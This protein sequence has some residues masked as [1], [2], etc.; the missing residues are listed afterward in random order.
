MDTPGFGHLPPFVTDA[1]GAE[2]GLLA[3]QR[4]RGGVPKIF[5]TNTAAE[6]WRGDCA[7]LHIDPLSKRDLDLPADSRAYLFAG[8]QHGSGIV[9]LYRH[10]PLDGTRG[11]HS[12]NA[13]D[14][15]PLLRAALSNLDAWVTAG[16]E[17]PSSAVPRLADGTAVLNT[18]A[19]DAYRNIPGATVPEPAWL[20]AL[21]PTDLG[22]EAAQ[23]IG[24]FPAIE[25]KPYPVYVSATDSDGNEAAGLRL[26][27]VSVPV[28][29]H[30][31]WNPRGAGIGGAGQ[32][33]ALQGST[34][35]FART[36]A[37]REASADPRPAINERYQGRTD[38]LTRVR[39]A[40]EKLVAQRALL[41]EDL[42]M[43]LR[44]TAE[45]YDALRGDGG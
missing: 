2:E 21:R 40:A 35:P 5:F 28:A 16:T 30:T 45:R 27:D 7:L 12:F 11:A 41:A 20:P 38:Y 32:L 9:P 18:T 14:Y 33:V 8:T 3:R 34:I 37:A 36:A 24:R 17:P 43:A 26:P 10:N 29:T 25:G 23:G 31:G 39:E 15:T 6:Y 1:N 19:L 13:L 42:E 4:A 44:A 22:P